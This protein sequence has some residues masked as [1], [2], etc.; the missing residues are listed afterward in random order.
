MPHTEYVTI[1]NPMWTLLMVPFGL[2]QHYLNTPGKGCTTLNGF[3]YFRQ[4]LWLALTIALLTAPS[5]DVM[6]ARIANDGALT[7]WLLTAIRY[8]PVAAIAAFSYVVALVFYYGVDDHIRRVNRAK[9]RAET[10]QRRR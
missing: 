9:R 4:V 8:I 5:Y 3:V 6:Q 10:R 1:I 7:H 2:L